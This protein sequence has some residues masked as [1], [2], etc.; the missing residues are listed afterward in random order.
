M[1]YD[2]KNIIQSLSDENI[3]LVKLIEFYKNELKNRNSTL[4]QLELSNKRKLE[5]ICHLA[6][7]FKTPLSAISGFATLMLDKDLDIETRL[8]FSQN[9]IKATEHL[10][11]L[12][13]YSLENARAENDNLP[14]NL[15]YFNPSEVIAEV[16]CVLNEK[17]K[18]KKL[19]IEINL[20]DFSIKADKRQFKQ[21]IY[22]LVGNAYK[23]NKFGGYIKIT[24]KLVDDSF[25]F[26]IE[27]T[28]CGIS[29]ENRDKI[30]EL[31]YCY[32][33]QELEDSEQTGIGLALC[34]KIIDL[35]GGKMDFDSIPN[36]GSV[37]WFYL[38]LLD[39]DKDADNVFIK[40]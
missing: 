5:F 15:Q 19:E 17:L 35:H 10:F 30:F 16:L 29:F 27:D 7:D 12:L 3:R 8:E 9:I 40:K 13:N 34:K 11:Q 20:C 23:Y 37:F 25:Y 24:T 26:E 6:H 2:Y 14:L 18:E 31:F 4:L 33:N 36:V 21:L 1:N 38:P 22:N 28:G 39:K 32:K